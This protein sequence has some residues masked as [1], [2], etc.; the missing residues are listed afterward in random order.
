MEITVGGLGHLGTLAAAGLAAQ[1]H[2]V[3]GVDLDHLLGGMLGVGAH[4]PSRLWTHGESA[5]WRKATSGAGSGV[6]VEVLSPV[7]VV[8]V[9]DDA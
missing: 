9:G 2:T 8:P 6:L 1:G 7:L 3:V 4:L 5:A